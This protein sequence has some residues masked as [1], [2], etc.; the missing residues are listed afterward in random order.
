VE[1]EMW[2]LPFYESG[3]NRVILGGGGAAFRCTSGRR[4]VEVSTESK[5]LRRIL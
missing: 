2:A 5:M 1:V 3:K 4:L